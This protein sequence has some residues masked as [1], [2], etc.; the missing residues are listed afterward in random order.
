MYAKQYVHY[1]RCFSIHRISDLRIMFV[2]IQHI[3][4]E[5]IMPSHSIS[6]LPPIS[7]CESRTHQSTSSTRLSIK[8]AQTYIFVSHLHIFPPTAKTGALKSRRLISLPNLSPDGSWRC[9]SATAASRFETQLIGKIWLLRNSVNQ[10]I[11]RVNN[12]QPRNGVSSPQLQ[13]LN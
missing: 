11:T 9:Q 5:T 6:R 13:L 2:F 1:L 12:G 3:R 10:I 4:N 8:L 7:R